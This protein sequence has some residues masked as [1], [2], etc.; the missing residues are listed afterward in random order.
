M[1]TPQ[2]IKEFEDEVL[3]DIEKP[4]NPLKRYSIEFSYRCSFTITDDA[5][6]TV[7][8]ETRSETLMHGTSESDIR[9]HLEKD[10]EIDGILK[11]KRILKFVKDRMWGIEPA[12]V[13]VEYGPDPIIKIAS[14]EKVQEIVEDYLD[15]I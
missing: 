15:E 6:T 5:Y 2:T 11:A 13:T 10:H 9:L 14:S 3:R 8:I 7:T 12:D 4:K 1:N